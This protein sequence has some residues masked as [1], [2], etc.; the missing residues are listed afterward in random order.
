MG[1]CS[2]VQHVRRLLKASEITGL[3]TTHVVGPRV[4]RG[5]EGFAIEACHITGCEGYARPVRWQ[6]QFGR[7][8]RFLPGL[9]MMHLVY[10][11]HTGG[12][13]MVLR[14]G[15]DIHIRV[16]DIRI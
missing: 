15:L 10:L 13:D 12:R 7:R 14:K 9:C 16:E 1:A 3:L 5:R 4:S 11:G 8:M 2:P 6:P